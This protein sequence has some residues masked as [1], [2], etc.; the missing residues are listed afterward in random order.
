MFF[1]VGLV[2]ELLNRLSNAAGTQPTTSSATHGPQDSVS[3]HPKSQS[4]EA[5]RS[6]QSISTTI[7]LLSTLCRGSP[8][9]THV[10]FIFFSPFFIWNLNFLDS[11]VSFYFRISCVQIYAKPWNEH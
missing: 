8:T 4:T 9:I 1:F 5:N 2:S 6:S 10:R 11:F 7:S 3:P